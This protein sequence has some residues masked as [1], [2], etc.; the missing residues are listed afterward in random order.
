MHTVVQVEAD[1]S[2]NET[3]AQTQVSHS[4]YDHILT[5]FMCLRLTSPP[6]GTLGD[7]F[8]PLE[9]SLASVRLICIVFKSSLRVP[10]HVCFGLPLYLVLCEK[11]LLIFFIQFCYSDFTYLKFLSHWLTGSIITHLTWFR[12]WVQHTHKIWCYPIA[13]VT[14]IYV[15]HANKS[16]ILTNAKP[17][18]L[19]KLEKMCEK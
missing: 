7:E 10:C 14:I 9:T 19:L 8:S 17:Y 3:R 12:Q 2:V 18:L 1:W 5:L 13:T 11:L 16:L 15:L 4:L 6:A